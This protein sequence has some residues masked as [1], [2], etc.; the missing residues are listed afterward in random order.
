MTLRGAILDLDGTVY[1]GDSPLP[2]ASRAVD[3][4]RDRGLSIC[5]FSNNPLHGGAEYV[6]RLQTLGID[7][8]AGEACSSAT[9]TRRYVDENHAD[10]A[11]FVVGDDSVRERIDR[12]EATVTEEPREADVLLASWTDEFHYRDM[13]AALRALDEDTA[14]LGTDPDVTFPD[15][16]G[17]PVPGSG[18]VVRAIA[19]VTER[20]P[21]AVLGKPSEWAVEAA[22]ERV[23]CP[24]ED[25]LVVG[26]RLDT[27]VAM[28]ERAGMTTVL[29]RSGVGD[30][31]A[32][33]GSDVTPDHVVDSLADVP[34]LLPAE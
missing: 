19:G 9:V 32:I 2:G 10:D 24:A 26:D 14:F 12:T 8:R 22:L 15:G 27:D 5:F 17:N 7:A 16:D 18:A 31:R 6:E 1:H 28:G 11:V 13:L 29:V 30:R 25:C 21:D 4:L 33:E 3:R 34:D 23:D 20:D